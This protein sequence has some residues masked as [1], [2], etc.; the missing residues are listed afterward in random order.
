M[1]LHC[2]AQLPTGSRAG[3]GKRTADANTIM[4]ESGET[5]GLSIIRR[6]LTQERVLDR[7]ALRPYPTQNTYYQF[8]YLHVKKTLCF[9]DGFSKINCYPIYI[10]SLFFLPPILSSFVSYRHSFLHLMDDFFQNKL[11][12]HLLQSSLLLSHVNIVFCMRQFFH[13]FS[14]S[15]Y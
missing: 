7:M 1:L 15:P 6:R 4:L 10:S 8:L 11:L 14:F 13:I 9:V 12:A 5:V 2:T 3:A